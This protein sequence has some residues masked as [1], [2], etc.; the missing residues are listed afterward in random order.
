MVTIKPLDR[1]MTG[2]E[3]KK[4]TFHLLNGA[5][6]CPD[7]IRDYTPLVKVIKRLF[8]EKDNVF[9]SIVTDHGLVGVFG[10]INITKGH[11]AQ[12]V[13]WFIDKG[14]VT[15][16]VVKNIRNFLTYCKDVYSLKRITAETACDKHERI[17]GI[18]GF[19]LEGRFRHGFKW[20]G[21]FRNLVR[22]RIIGEL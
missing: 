20:H 15:A 12:F 5:Y 10:I 6:A 11:N 17:L 18:I 22:M 9:M 16:G 7:A 4:W 14:S 1:S 2:D 21:G 3:F 8:D 13:S 19:K